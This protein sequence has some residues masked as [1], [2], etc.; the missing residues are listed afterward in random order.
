MQTTKISQA[1]IIQHANLMSN[2]PYQKAYEMY[3]VCLKEYGAYSTVIIVRLAEIYKKT[4]CG[5][6]KRAEAVRLQSEVLKWI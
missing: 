3:R 5:Q 4:K 2:L 6:I 1:D